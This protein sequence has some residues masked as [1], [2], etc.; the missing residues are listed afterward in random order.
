VSQGS[1]GFIEVL[2][3]QL[4]AGRTLEAGEACEP[5][6]ARCRVVVDERFAEVF[7]PGETAIGKVF[8][9]PGQRFVVNGELQGQPVREVVGLV[10]DSLHG[11]PR[12]EAV[13]TIY[14]HLD[15]FIVQFSDHL[16]I[17]AAIDPAALA[18]AVRQA[19]GRVDPAVPLAEFHTKSGLVD[20]LLRTERLLAL[21]SGAFG[22][23][24]LALAALGLGGLLAYAVARR[25][26]EIGIRM[27]LGATGR[28]VRRM[29]L[30]RLVRRPVPGRSALRTGAR[31]CP[32]GVVG[33]GYADRHCGPGLSSPGA[34]CSARESDDRPSGR[35][36][37]V[38]SSGPGFARRHHL[39]H[40]GV[41]WIRAPGLASSSN[42][43]E[44]SGP[45]ATSRIRLPTS[46]RSAAT[47]P[48]LPSKT[49]RLSD[50][51]PI[52]DTNPFPSHSGKV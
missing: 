21:V 3:L 17:R 28:E 9:V 39:N 49:M 7:F 33:A 46:Q 19:A 42:H 32:D 43:S 40:L 27:A 12:G 24:A 41:T 20:R 26:N 30:G 51:V 35:V 34:P 45:S 31:G 25:T 5:G 36:G 22:L 16:A 15:S 44:P 2:G 11:D 6:S 13:P 47:A 10:A 37:Q 23:A 48:P 4:L 29:V 1:P 18:G 38:R 8:E 52:P 50:R 14:Q